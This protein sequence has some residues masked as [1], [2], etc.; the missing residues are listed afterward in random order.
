V[1][2]SRSR[3][4]RLTLL[5]SIAVA[6]L[7][8]TALVALSLA[9]SD[10]SAQPRAE[11]ATIWV[12]QSHPGAPVPQRFLGLSFELSS[13][14][15]IASY[16]NRGDMANLLRSLGPGVLRFGGA[17]ADSRVAWSDPATPR[18][19][20]ASSVL[21]VGE[22]RELR[23]LAEESGW[24]VLLTVGLAHFDPRA[25]AR[26]VAA[27]KG[28]LGPWL[29]GIEVGNEPDAYARHGFR[30]EP[31]GY[32]QYEAQVASYM[33]AIAALVPGVPLAGPGVSGSSVFARWGPREAAGARPALLT[34]HHYP[35]GCHN[36]IAPSI[37]RLLSPQIRRLEGV[38]LA[39]F[40]SVSRKS[41]IGLRVD[42]TN[43]VSCGG[44]AG[45]SN[46]FA[47]AL[48]AVSYIAQTMSAGA[49]GINLQ[50]NPANCR[51][52]SPLCAT[53][54]TSLTDGALGAQP[55]W[56]A[57]LLMKGLIGDRPLRARLLT[58]QRPNVTT[59]A[60]LA[61]DGSVH[62]VIVDDDPR[63]SRPVELRVHVGRGFESARVL[64]LTAPALG[65][66]SGVE[67]GGR[68]VARDGSW[69]GPAKPDDLAVRGGV[70]T[71]TVAPASAALV[72]VAPVRR[73]P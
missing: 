8:L 38:S 54:A 11:A 7:A 46:T 9:A 52:Y 21:E 37:D 17:S 35:L 31:W 19:A 43:T 62:V 27:A 4:A 26:E 67:L 66:V 33:Q 55:E 18:P 42:E 58:P 25:A 39:R 47:S 49:S 30:E 5:L 50:G 69:Q 36:A 53:T 10:G 28:A 68:P 60:L 20:W 2:R 45:I 63:G 61:G 22:L 64:A 12:D 70:V 29:A 14:G 16:S 23:A 40:M 6:G 13:L 71:L 48:W 73:R 15:Q 34:G 59:T 72:S 41:E 3:R 51:G 57:L 65:A 32:E 44:E 56:Y 24:P 1:G